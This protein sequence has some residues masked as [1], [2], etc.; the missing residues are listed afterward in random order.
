MWKE[1]SIDEQKKF[2]EL[3]EELE[4]MEIEIPQLPYEGVGYKFIYDGTLGESGVDG[5]NM[6]NDITGG[7]STKRTNYAL[8]GGTFDGKKFEWYHGWLF[9]NDKINLTNYKKIYVSSNIVENGSVIYN[10]VYGWSK[11]YANNGEVYPYPNNNPLINVEAGGKKDFAYYE[12]KRTMGLIDIPEKWEGYIGIY[13][14]HSAGNTYY[15]DYQTSYVRNF[16]NSGRYIDVYSIVALKEDD[17]KA[18]IKLAK[19]DSDQFTSLSE[20]LEN[21]EVL[22][23]AFSKRKA[24]EYLLKCS[25][26]LMVEI[27]K[28]DKSYKL[29][30]KELI[31]EMQNNENWNHFMKVCELK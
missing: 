10:Y 30:P 25:G 24:N 5:K 28:N 14:C 6:C 31:A 16:C 20:I 9:T 15:Y 3:Y 8:K 21:E 19:I 18:W 11:Q 26:T 13:S 27:L 29:I 2:N 1:A 4:N 22:Q 7:W 12:N 23:K 17:W